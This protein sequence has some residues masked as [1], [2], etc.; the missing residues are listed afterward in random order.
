[1]VMHLRD[2]TGTPGFENDKYIIQEDG[3]YSVKRMEICNQYVLTF[4]Q[5]MTYQSHY[6]LVVSIMS[7]LPGK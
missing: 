1:M 3:I 6:Y 4:K 7:S 2:V 5:S